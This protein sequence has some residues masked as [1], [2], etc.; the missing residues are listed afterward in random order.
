MTKGVWACTTSG[1]NREASRTGLNTSTEYSN[2]GYGRKVKH[3]YL[4]TSAPSIEKAPVVL[5]AVN[6]LTWCPLPASIRSK[7]RT[8]FTTPLTFGMNV[9]ENTAILMLISY[10]ALLHNNICVG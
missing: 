3:L 9:S 1:P 6:T 8:A 10:A 2:S 4:Y 7:L 5:P